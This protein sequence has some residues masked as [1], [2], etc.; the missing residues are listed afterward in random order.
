M[1]EEKKSF[2]L[3][4]TWEEQIELLDMAQRG[5]LLTA[6]FAYENRGECYDGGDKLI[7][8][9]FRTMRVAMDDNRAKWEARA[10]RSRENGALGGRPKKNRAGSMGFDPKTGKPVSGYGTANGTE[11]VFSSGSGAPK[12]RSDTVVLKEY[13]RQLREAEAQAA[14]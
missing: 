7:M 8:M 6:L 14:E 9:A 12:D 10:Q 1:S 11:S 5:E 4:C 3:Y 2:I 13:M